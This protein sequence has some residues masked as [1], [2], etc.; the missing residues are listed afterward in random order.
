MPKTLTIKRRVFIYCCSWIFRKHR[1]KRSASFSRQRQF[2]PCCCI[3]H[4]FPKTHNTHMD[5]HKHACTLS[6]LA[7]HTQTHCR[8]R[9]C[10]YR[11]CPL[12]S[13]SFSSSGVCITGSHRRFLVLS[14]DIL[15]PN[16]RS[17]AHC[18]SGSWILD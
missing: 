12:P 1:H 5:I 16:S 14:R 13:F 8:C 4:F 18:S 15:A 3:Y 10:L 6:L 11:P 17:L 2:P 7:V 9:S